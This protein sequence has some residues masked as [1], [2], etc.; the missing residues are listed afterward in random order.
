MFRK[1]L[2]PQIFGAW[3]DPLRERHALALPELIWDRGGREGWFTTYEGTNVLARSRWGSPLSLHLHY[4]IMECTYLGLAMHLVFNMVLKLL[5]PSTSHIKFEKQCH[6]KNVQHDSAKC[7][8]WISTIRH[9]SSVR[10]E[11]PAWK[12]PVKAMAPTKIHLPKLGEK[13]IISQFWS[14]FSEDGGDD[15]MN[16]LPMMGSIF[17]PIGNHSCII[18]NWFMMGRK[19]ISCRLWD[20]WIY[21]IAHC[22]V[23]RIQTTIPTPLHLHQQLQLNGNVCRRLF[24]P[25]RVHFGRNSIIF[26]FRW[27]GV[28]QRYSMT[29]TNK[30]QWIFLLLFPQVVTT[31][32]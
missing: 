5:W 18:A 7:N 24:P 29:Y 22:W 10:H 14:A 1:R 19:M 16:S 6:A 32:K 9:V 3:Q 28:E 21:H 30:I 17:W 25:R 11:T 27:F 31:V 23:Q 4:G 15:R 8:P 20:H 13:N 2:L 12:E 26:S